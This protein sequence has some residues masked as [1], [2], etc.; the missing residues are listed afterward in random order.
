MIYILKML[1]YI[2]NAFIY[3]SILIINKIRSLIIKKQILPIYYMVDIRRKI[4]S[5]IIKKQYL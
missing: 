4:T 5:K 1:T 3:F 2:L